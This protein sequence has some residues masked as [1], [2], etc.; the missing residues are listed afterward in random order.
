MPVTDDAYLKARLAGL[1][2]TPSPSGHTDDL[3]MEPA[4]EAEWDGRDDPPPRP[5]G[6]TETA[7]RT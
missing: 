5:S 3:P 1:L 2:N 7:G 4:Q 6:P